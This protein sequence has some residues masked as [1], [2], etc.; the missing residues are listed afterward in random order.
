MTDNPKIGLHEKEVWTKRKM[1]FI[2]CLCPQWT[3]CM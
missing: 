1:T 3:Y 2:V